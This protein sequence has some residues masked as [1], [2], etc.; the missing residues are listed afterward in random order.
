V[1]KR[2]PDVDICNPMLKRSKLT[3]RMLTFATHICK[4]NVDICKA[5]NKIH[6]PTK[7]KMG[8]RCQHP[9]FKFLNRRHPYWPVSAKILD[10]QKSTSVIYKNRFKMTHTDLNMDPL[11]K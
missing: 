5:S 7:K 11:H 9:Q 3:K 10:L 1:D 2:E 6:T 4:L 8:T